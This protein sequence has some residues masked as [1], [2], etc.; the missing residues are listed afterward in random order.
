MIEIFSLVHSD[1]FLYFII[2][3]KKSFYFVSFAIVILLLLFTRSLRCYQIHMAAARA[4]RERCDN[5]ATRSFSEIS[6][7]SDLRYVYAIGVN[8]SCRGNINAHN[9]NKKYKGEIHDSHITKSPEPR[10]PCLIYPIDK[11]HIRFRSVDQGNR[12]E[13]SPLSWNNTFLDVKLAFLPTQ[14]F[15]RSKVF[16]ILQK[17]KNREIWSVKSQS[18]QGLL[19]IM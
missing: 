4:S 9:R 5:G 6:R 15:F 19:C 3:Y 12:L 11:W 7:P 2:L 18:I 8:K 14:D 13:E 16:Q 17:K 1:N 10:I